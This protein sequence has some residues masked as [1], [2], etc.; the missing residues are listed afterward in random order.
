[1]SNPIVSAL[2]ISSVHEEIDGRVLLVLADK[3]RMAIKVSG[4]WAEKHQPA[5]DG[6][7][8]QYADGEAAFSA[9]IVS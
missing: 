4:E 3:T 1:M 2:R 6:Y 7:Y 5:A 8:V 9:E